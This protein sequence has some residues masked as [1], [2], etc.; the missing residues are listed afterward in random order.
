[1]KI[2]IKVPTEKK[3][4]WKVGLRRASHKRKSAGGVYRVL[5]SIISDFLNSDANEKLAIKVKYSKGYTN[6]TIDSRDKNY[7]LYA[8]T[9]FLEDYLKK[10]FIRKMN[11]QCGYEEPN[12]YGGKDE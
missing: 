4:F 12:Y 11:K 1:M 3:N 8:T 2:I 5:K 6:E 7:L 9:C 10:G